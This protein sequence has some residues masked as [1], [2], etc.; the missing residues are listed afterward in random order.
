MFVHN[1]AFATIVVIS[2]TKRL[3]VIV[4]EPL[5]SAVVVVDVVDV[6]VVVVDVVVVVVGLSAKHC[7][8]KSLP[9]HFCVSQQQI[10]MVAPLSYL[11][12]YIVAPL[13]LL[14]H[15]LGVVGSVI[16]LRFA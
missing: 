9:L 7:A 5:G 14:Q 12:Y 6:V 3:A 1:N 10:F 2:I 8:T 11:L 16:H 4:F 15:N 13:L